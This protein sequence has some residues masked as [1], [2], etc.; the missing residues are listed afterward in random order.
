[1]ITACDRAK[2]K[3]LRA[4]CIVD[5]QAPLL[6]A[7]MLATSGMAV[8]L[9]F[10]ANSPQFLSFPPGTPLS[11]AGPTT[12]RHPAPWGSAPGGAFYNQNNLGA[13][14]PGCRVV[15]LNVDGFVGIGGSAKHHV[16]VAFEKSHSSGT[17]N[18][19][20]KSS[21]IGSARACDA[22]PIKAGSS[23]QD[24]RAIGHAGADGT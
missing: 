14:R 5:D 22:C 21:R 3:S 4:V 18:L 12:K 17:P 7:R 6:G 16:T 13:D 20:D 15:N 10:S 11:I 9:T 23:T 1:M 2:L 19:T 24:R 8:T